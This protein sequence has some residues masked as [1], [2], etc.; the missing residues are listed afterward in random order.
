[1]QCKVIARTAISRE[2]QSIFIKKQYG[3]LR[4]TSAHTRNDRAGVQIRYNFE[5]R[6]NGEQASI[7]L[8]CATRRAGA[9]RHRI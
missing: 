1:M 3:L 2:K 5:R 7:F 9:A 4:F 8:L 6:A